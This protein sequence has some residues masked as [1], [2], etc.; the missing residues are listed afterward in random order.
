MAHQITDRDGLFTVREAA[1]HGLGEV[2]TDYPTRVEAQQIAHPWEPVAEPVYRRVLH[3]DFTETYEE[4]TEHVLN[5]RSDT[6]APLG[7]VADS[8]TPVTNTEMWD[9]AEAIEGVNATDVRYETGG[10][11]KGCL[12]YTSDAADEL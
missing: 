10:S 1:W 6:G 2:L 8:Y 12:L 4:V 7:V 11:L 5:V 3:P 9:I